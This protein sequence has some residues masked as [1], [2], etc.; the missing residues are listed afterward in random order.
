MHTCRICTTCVCMHAYAC[1]AMAPRGLLVLGKALIEAVM[2]TCYRV[3][4]GRTLEAD[5]QITT[6][7]DGE[8]YCTLLVTNVTR[9]VTRVS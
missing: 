5:T 2:E 7:S 8:P 9:S 4:R 1:I 3:C 6:V